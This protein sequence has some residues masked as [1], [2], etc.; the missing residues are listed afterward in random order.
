MAYET[1][2]RSP[3]RCA[4]PA[5]IEDLWQGIDDRDRGEERPCLSED[6]VIG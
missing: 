2:Y 4:P 5:I 6:E 3:S 1:I